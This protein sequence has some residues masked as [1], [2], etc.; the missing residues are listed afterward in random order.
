MNESAARGFREVYI[1]FAPKLSLQASS[2][3]ISAS[4]TELKNNT[5]QQ[6]YDIHPNIAIVKYRFSPAFCLFETLI[7]RVNFGNGNLQTAI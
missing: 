1:D 7:N 2:S 3:Y 6:Y 4:V 5:G